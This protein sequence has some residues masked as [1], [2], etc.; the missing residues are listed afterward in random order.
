MQIDEDFLIKNI[1]MDTL[2]ALARFLGLRH[3]CV[4][5]AKIVFEDSTSRLKEAVFS[6]I[7]ENVQSVMA[8]QIRKEFSN[9]FFSDL[10]LYLAAQISKLVQEGGKKRM[11]PSQNDLDGESHELKK[12]KKSDI[13]YRNGTL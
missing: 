6:F 8:S 5:N 2:P 3:E 9:G 13:M 10:T 7:Q 11:E 1:E 12:T 4:G